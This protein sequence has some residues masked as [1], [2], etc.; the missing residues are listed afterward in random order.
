M[1]LSLNGYIEIV[2]GEYKGKVNVGEAILIKSKESHSFSAS[3]GARF[4][5]V[6]MDTLPTNIETGSNRK[7]SISDSMLAYIQF[8][9]KQLQSSTTVSAEN[10]LYSLFLELLKNEPLLGRVDRR[11]EHAIALIHSDLSQTYSINE[12]ARAACLG[13]T[14]FKKLFSEGTGMSVSRYLVKVKMEKARSLLIY[15]DCPITQVAF[16]LGYKNPSSFT[17]RFTQYFSQSPTLFC[18]KH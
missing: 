16:E 9:E 18:S 17:R 8:I 6:D 13:Q 5:V 15:T 2:V 10:L 14:Q 11:I 3:E 4:V 12:L 1:V 7:F